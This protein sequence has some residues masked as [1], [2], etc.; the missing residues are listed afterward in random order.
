MQRTLLHGLCYKKPKL[1]SMGLWYQLLRK[2][3]QE[4]EKLKAC[5]S[6][7]INSRP[8]QTTHRDPISKQKS[9]KSMGWV[10]GLMA[11]QLPILHK[12]LGSIPSY[13]KQVQVLIQTWKCRR[14]W[15]N[16]ETGIRV[17]IP[18]YAD[19][20]SHWNCSITNTIAL[21]KTQETNIS[22]RH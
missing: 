1:S 20:T 15:G 9:N 13:I 5:L 16:K 22:R 4:D 8:Y 2:L 19:N 7:R 18:E 11:Q 6:Y 21:L 17:Y 3:R 10:Y 12:V 14:R